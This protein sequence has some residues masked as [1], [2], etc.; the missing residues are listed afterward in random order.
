MLFINKQVK[1]TA[2]YC[3]SSICNWWYQGELGYGCREAEPYINVYGRVWLYTNNKLP[4]ET[5]HG[6]NNTNG[7]ALLDE[8]PA[9]VPT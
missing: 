6:N 2:G 1:S 4:D 7:T 3:I 8:T 9:L 5:D